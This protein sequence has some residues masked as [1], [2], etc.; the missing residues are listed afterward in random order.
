[1]KLLARFILAGALGVVPMV[2]VAAAPALACG[3]SYR[4]EVDPKTNALVK[5]EEALHEG[6]YKGA[7]RLAV[8]ATGPVGKSVEGKG[9][10]AGIDPLRARTLR[11]ASIAVVRTGGTVSGKP[12]ADAMMTWAVDQ[13]RV[14]VAR[15]SQNP[16]LVA[17]LAHGLAL[18]PEGRAEALTLLAELAKNDMMPTAQAWLLYGELAT[19]Q[20]ERERAIDQ[21]KLRASDPTVCK[22][23]APGET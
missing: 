12:S 11:V 5:A 4:Y 13:L 19:D 8:S 22:L 15:E 17:Q 1:M 23:K 3:N 16:Y 14:L 2:T 10:P 20:K 7:W 21:C 6:D 18:K 9:D